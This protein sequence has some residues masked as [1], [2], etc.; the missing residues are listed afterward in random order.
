[1]LKKNNMVCFAFDVDHEVVMH[2]D[3]CKWGMKYRSVIGFGKASFVEDIQEK[4]EGLNAIM[5]HYS[6]GTYDYPEAAVN[7]TLVIKVAI[8]SLTGKKSGY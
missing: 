3:A 6:G 8:E 5:E 2:E 7:N 1:M 4:K